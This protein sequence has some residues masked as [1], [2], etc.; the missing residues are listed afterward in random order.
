LAGVGI[1]NLSVQPHV[2][3]LV[4]TEVNS[5]SYEELKKA[6]DIL[7]GG[8]G[9]LYGSYEKRTILRHDEN[10]D[11]PKSSFLDKKDTGR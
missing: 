3:S 5:K 1:K 9:D 7:L 8:Y 10:A 11:H 2:I 4:R 6:A